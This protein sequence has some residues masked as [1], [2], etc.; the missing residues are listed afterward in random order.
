MASAMMFH[1]FSILFLLFTSVLA[2]T[3]KAIFLGP[4][5]VTVPLT[6]PTLSDLRLHTLT[7]T[8]I[9]GTLRTQLPAQFPSPKHPQGTATWLI[10]DNL[11]PNQRYEVRVCWA[12]T[13]P[14]DF[15]LTTFPLTTVWD[16][17]ELMTSLHAYATS[18]QQKLTPDANTA[19]PKADSDSGSGEREASILFLRILAAADYFTT[20]AS[21]MRDVPPVDVDV[22]LDPFLFNVL[23]RSIAGTACYIVAV[24]AVA[25]LVARWTTG[26]IRGLVAG[27]R[28][29]V[30]KRQ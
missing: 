24:A 6:H 30:K 21:L 18:Q 8:P 15:T 19:P 16:T 20:D 12:A 2:N 3:E 5:P 26:R 1:I 25:F 17:P 4:E 13:Q 7:P 29:S 22:I 10:L 11:T 14:T 28:G 27:A 9:N 23:P